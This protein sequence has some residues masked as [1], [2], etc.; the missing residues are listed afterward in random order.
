MEVEPH[1]LIAGAPHFPV[2]YAWKTYLTTLRSR[3]ASPERLGIQAPSGVLR[4][5]AAQNVGNDWWKRN[6]GP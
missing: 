1:A 5:L 6:S 3:S 2:T 4:G